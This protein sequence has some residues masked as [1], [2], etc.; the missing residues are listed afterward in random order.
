MPSHH[1]L[2]KTIG[3]AVVFCPRAKLAERCPTEGLSTRRVR[4]VFLPD[5]KCDSQG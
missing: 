2:K 1:V 5:Q 3:Y 4:E